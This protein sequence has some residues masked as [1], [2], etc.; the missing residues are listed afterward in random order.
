[1]TRG[2]KG[3]GDIISTVTIA[4]LFF[5]IL[6]LVMFS[7]SSYRHAADVEAENSHRRA[8]LSYVASGIRDNRGSEIKIQDRGTEDQVT[9]KSP[10]SRFERRIYLQDG[11]LYEEYAEDDIAQDPEN[12][13]VIGETALFDV[14][15]TEDGLIRIKTDAGASYVAAD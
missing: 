6:L 9:I 12:A 13:L 2:R 1:M 11:K 15:R 10:G 3:I 4:V 8:L 5:V 7:A 14:E